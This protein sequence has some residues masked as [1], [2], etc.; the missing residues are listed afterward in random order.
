MNSLIQA[1]GLDLR[2]LLAQFVNFS[3]LVFVLWRFAYKPV[4][5]I[6]E[7]RRLKIE[8]GVK[9]S[10][11]AEEKLSLAVQESKTII[12]TAR[13]EASAIIDEAQGRGEAR[14]QEVVLKAKEDLRVIMDKEK[15][16]LQQEKQNLVAQVKTE[17]SE[18]I[19]KSL[20]KFLG[21][22]MNADSDQKV[23]EKIIKEL[24]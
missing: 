15:E 22:N 3:V 2:I 21:T 4:L 7:E 12:A 14:Y 23:I 5:K 1:L 17:A 16:K 10:E 9:D 13:Q 24:S 19:I 6:L 11:A 18:L 20:E 8:Q